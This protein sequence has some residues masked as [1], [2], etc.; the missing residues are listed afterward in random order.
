MSQPQLKY[1]QEFQL[2]D[3]AVTNFAVCTFYY[4]TVTLF[5]EFS[6]EKKKK[7]NKNPV[8]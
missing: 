6:L 1:A 8:E 5:G 2:T 4:I 3:A 7:K